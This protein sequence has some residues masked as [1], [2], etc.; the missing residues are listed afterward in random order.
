MTGIPDSYRWV[1]TDSNMTA[2]RYI[3]AASLM[4]CSLLM[5]CAKAM[6]RARASDEG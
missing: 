1:L 5:A 3:G 6:H 2:D 4:Y